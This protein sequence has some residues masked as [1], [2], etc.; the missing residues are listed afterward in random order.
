MLIPVIA[1]WV[2]TVLAFYFGRENY[3]AATK[4]AERLTSAQ[5]L[6][7]LKAIEVG[8]P[9]A[10]VDVLQLENPNNDNSYMP[11]NTL[12]AIV[13][14]RF[15]TTRRARL[16]ILLPSGAPYMVL[17]RSEFH[18]FLVESEGDE[19][20]KKT[21]ND[22]VAHNGMQPERSF[23]TVSPN[24]TAREARQALESLNT[25]ATDAFVTETGGPDSRALYWF[26]NVDL[27]KAAEV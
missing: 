12:L 17:H 15:A 20:E 21:I 18:R 19:P 3:E 26:T 9:M 24:A 8:R 27:L 2:G 22:L 25:G 10:Q 6:S 13:K 11:G 14:D 16:P 23:A 5:K 7:N 1:G 4:A